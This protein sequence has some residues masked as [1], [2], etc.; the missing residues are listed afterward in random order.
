MDELRALPQKL[1]AC[2]AGSRSVEAVAAR[3]QDK[4][5]FFYLGRHAGLPVCLEGA[6]KLKEIAYIPTEAY[7]A[8]EM[9]HGPIALLDDQTPVV[10]VATD[11]PRR[12]QAAVE[13]AG[14]TRAGARGHRDRDGG[15]SGHRRRG[16]PRSSRCR[17]PTR[18]CSRC[19]R[20]SRS[21]CS[22][23]T[24]PS[25]R[26]EDVDQPRNLAKTVTVE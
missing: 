21:S 14:S 26:G 24:S 23:T 15:R 18:C 17:A 2:L 10:C 6:L 16:G 13:P 3:H 22:P 19:S 7:A 12:R 5:F 4:P 20:S 8:G 11:V 25:A 1:A 9:K